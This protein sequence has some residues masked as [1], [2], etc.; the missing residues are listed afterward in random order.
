MTK[1]TQLRKD[2]DKVDLKILN[3][4]AQRK[5]LVKK[6]MKYKFEQN[7]PLVNQ[8]REREIISRLVSQRKLSSLQVRAL[9]KVL[10]G[11]SH[12]LVKK[13]I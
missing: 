7:M 13:N 9:W 8:K 4:V 1:L 11:M 6:M 12:K 5:N 2:I 3:C 10:F